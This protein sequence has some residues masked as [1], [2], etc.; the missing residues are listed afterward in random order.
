MND[1]KPV[2]FSDHEVKGDARSIDHSSNCWNLLIVDD[3]EEVH[4]VTRLVL[5]KVQVLGKYISIHSAYSAKQA[6]ELMSNN[7]EF[8]FALIDVVMETNK[9]GLE[10]IKWIRENKKNSNVRLVLRTGQPDEVPEI[11]IISQYDIHDYKEKSDLTAKK[12]YTLTFSCIR[13]YRDIVKAKKMK[14]MLRHS[15]KMDILGK[16]AS[17]IVHDFNN[18]LGVIIANSELLKQSIYQNDK[19]IEKIQRIEKA[20]TMGS[21][22][23]KKL[24]FLSINKAEQKENININHAIYKMDIIIGHTTSNNTQLQYELD[25]N[26]W[27]TSVHTGDF[28]SAFFNLLINA[29]HAISTNGRIKIETRNCLIDEVFCQS[30]PFATTGEFVQLSVSDNGKGMSE[31]IRQ[32]VFEPFFTTKETGTGLGLAMVS[33]FVSQSLGYI[34]IDSVQDVGTCFTIYLPR[35]TS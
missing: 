16:L 23:T 14:H 4:S 35:S 12:L 13:A 20:A 11:E 21:N 33:E 18:I 3:D 29:N 27:L 9:A 31:K 10:L 7:I 32:N 24:Q 6:K 26:I 15:E 25:D 1:N 22:L 5:K 30:H 2:S 28:E 8:S 19:Q 34:T 17:G